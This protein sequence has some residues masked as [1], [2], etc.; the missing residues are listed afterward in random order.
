VV[1]GRF[2]QVPIMQEKS[3]GDL[4]ICYDPESKKFTCHN[5]H[6]LFLDI[7]RA[8]P[9]TPI[10]P[11]TNSRYPK[12]FI[13]RIRQRYPEFISKSLTPPKK[14][15]PEMKEE[16]TF[17]FSRPVRLVET[18]VREEKEPDTMEDLE[19]MVSND[20]TIAVVYFYTMWCASC[21]SILGFWEEMERTYAHVD[22]IR[23]NKDYAEELVINYRIQNVPVFVFF[24][25]TPEGTL[26]EVGPRFS[27]IYTKELEETINNLPS[28]GR[29]KF[30]P[31]R[32]EEPVSIMERLSS[33]NI[34]SETQLRTFLPE[35]KKAVVYFTS[36][37]CKRCHKTVK[38]GKDEWK[39]G[40][41]QGIEEMEEKWEELPKMFPNILFVKANLELAEEFFEAK[42]IRTVPFFMVYIK[43]GNG[44]L[45]P[46]Y[47]T[48]RI[49][50]VENYLR[51]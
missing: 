44:D 30:F 12:E 45:E 20:G 26:Q 33:D 39:E 34:T 29:P 18:S 43:D 23:V 32:S 25:K 42:K 46:I 16:E 35:K 9:S 31:K 47:S 13:E 50:N 6:E 1:P 4:V 7:R 40:P 24:Q 28:F 19:K 51:D 38:E 3:L 17:H 21:R 36:T 37:K 8:G 11:Y 27:G 14:P 10:N 2:V 48:A 49:S 22:F 41:Q 15:P 5:L